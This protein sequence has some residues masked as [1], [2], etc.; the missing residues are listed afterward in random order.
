M[1]S[2]TSFLRISRQLYIFSHVAPASFLFFSFLQYKHDLIFFYVLLFP[3]L[4][5]IINTHFF[6]SLF[7]YFSREFNTAFIFFI[8][9]F[10]TDIFWFI[11]HC[12][13]ELIRHL[14]YFLYYLS[15]IRH[16]SLR[17]LKMAA[18]QGQV[19]LIKVIRR[20]HWVFVSRIFHYFFLS[21][22]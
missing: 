7:I 20:G 22:S 8:F 3:F 14:L 12:I 15:L 2:F 1:F 19:I 17:G 6:F 10:I 18:A 13:M 5:F 4:Y 16:A 9:L 11:F 21:L